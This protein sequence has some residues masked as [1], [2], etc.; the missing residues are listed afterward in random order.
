VDHTAVLA[1]IGHDK[2]AR[3][4]R[5]PFVLAPRIGE[6]RL[7]QDVPRDVVHSV[8]SDLARDG[9]LEPQAR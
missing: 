5:V 7:V 1:A 4:G 2:K 6:F 3:E 9:A 8:L